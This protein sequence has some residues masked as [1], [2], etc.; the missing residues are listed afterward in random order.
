MESPLEEFSNYRVEVS[1]WDSRE[2]FFVEKTILTW[3]GAGGKEISLQNGL[4]KGCVVFV[5]L[6]QTMP[7]ATNFPVAYQ[8]MEIFAKD[9]AGRWRVS[10]EQIHPRETMREQPAENE[11]VYKV[12]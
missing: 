10:L 9:C 3:S 4:R 1:G 11:D 8:T 7:N 5:R 6:L 12:A 2:N